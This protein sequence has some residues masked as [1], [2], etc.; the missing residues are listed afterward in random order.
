MTVLVAAVA[1]L[2]LLAVAVLVLVLVLVFVAPTAGLPKVLRVVVIHLTHNTAL[3]GARDVLDVHE[4][5]IGPTIAAG[6][7]ESAAAGF[8]EV[9]HSGVLSLDKL[10][11]VEAPSQLHERALGILLVVVLHVHVPDH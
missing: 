5:T 10:T 6:F 4:I 3:D 8:A 7:M 9:G 1:V 11:T 2:V